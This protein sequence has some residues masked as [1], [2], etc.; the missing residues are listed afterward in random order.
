MYY[1]LN[2]TIILDLC[3]NIYCVRLSFFT[4]FDN[5]AEFP[6]FDNDGLVVIRELIQK[7]WV[8]LF[9]LLKKFFGSRFGPLVIHEDGKICLNNLYKFYYFK[10]K[11]WIKHKNTEAIWLN[12][13]HLKL[14]F[15]SLAI[16]C[17][18]LHPQQ[19]H[20]VPSR[21]MCQ[22][23]LGSFWIQFLLANFM[24]GTGC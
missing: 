22:R 2:A 8:T 14:P 17:C 4:F 9:L 16:M 23:G 7:Y 12:G 13:L 5:H 3:S 21:Y 1:T 20:F 19:V 11:Q 15:N 10:N 24:D 6:A 18:G